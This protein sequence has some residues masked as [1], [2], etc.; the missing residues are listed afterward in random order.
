MR[1]LSND[2]PQ[3]VYIPYYMKIYDKESGE[4]FIEV[5][6][7]EVTNHFAQDLILKPIVE[8]PELREKFLRA[9]DVPL[10]FSDEF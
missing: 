10:K 4:N 7:K 3:I 8:Y 5:T 6:F 1:G 2:S 9:F